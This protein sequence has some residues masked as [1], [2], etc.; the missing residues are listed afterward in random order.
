V[1]LIELDLYAPPE[2]AP[3][4]RPGA[5]RRLVPLVGVLLVTLS[6]TGAG[7]AASVLWR[8]LGEVPI[9]A[10]DGSY[11]IVGGRLYTFA[12]AAGRLTTTAWSMEPLRRLWSRDTPARVPGPNGPQPGLGYSATA[13]GADGVLL[14]S[15]RTSALADAAT[16]RIRWQLPEVVRPLPGAR[17]G[18]VYDQE[19]RPGDNYDQAKGAQGPLYFADDGM[20]HTQPP[21]RTTLRAI[22]LVTGRERWHRALPGIAVAAGEPGHPDGVFVVSPERL[23][24]LDA[25]SGRV[26]RER[27]LDGPSPRDL[28]LGDIVDGLVLVRHGAAGNG[29]TVTAYSATTL[30]RQ[31]QR[32]ESIDGG[33]VA[34]CDGVLCEQEA[35]GV[36]VLDPASGLA[37]WHTDN[38]E[39]L[40]AH[41]S[42]LVEMSDGG[43]RPMRAR[44]VVTGAVRADLSRWAFAT[45]S[46]PDAPLI[47]MQL[48]GG[49]TVF[50]VLPVGR[51]TVQPLG[52]ASTPVI[53][54]S[55]DFR[56]V[57]CRLIDGVE[58]FAY[59]PPPRPAHHG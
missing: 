29:G 57:V 52:Y 41:G 37:R 6:L 49:R 44:D 16:G 56:H 27:T 42:N 4:P 18:L 55:S 19:F 48:A 31:W 14:R 28:S 7:P 24:I 3:G 1:A 2:P 51:T 47:L 26:L 58:V 22:D 33:P 30:D 39:G 50:G 59:A 45:D 32:P 20:F 43:S 8:R 23:E 54:C 53:D 15:E 17:T 10:P 38:D 11:A 5:R 13:V 34:F 35:D 36:A 25:G 9:S 40:V 21:V 12:G 46:P